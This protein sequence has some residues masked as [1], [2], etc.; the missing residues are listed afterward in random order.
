[1]R[2]KFLF[3]PDWPRIAQ[4]IVGLFFV[5]CAFNKGID[6]FF[7]QASTPLRVDLEWWISQD[8]P[9]WGYQQ[10]LVLMLPYSQIL[11]ALVIAL[12]AT[13]GLSLF[14]DINKRIGAFLLLF[15]QTNIF[16]ATALG[17]I[18]F[19][20]FIGMSIW[21][22]VYYFWQSAMTTRKRRLLTFLLIGMGMLFQ[23]QRYR[24]GDPWLSSF[25]WQESH[26]AADT[27]STS[28]ALKTL[29]LWIVER[30]IG[31]WLWASMWWITAALLLLMLTRFRLYA[32]SLWLLMLT[33]RVMIW[34][35]AVTSEGVL[36]VLT[37]FVWM[38][39]EESWQRSHPAARKK[40][41][42][43]FP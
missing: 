4:S 41:Y 35:N 1:M 13:A 17:G 27:M 10:F 7:G 36:W 11:A 25:Q 16:L 20:T 42:A 5:A 29:V 31:P 32:G 39:A 22:A 14:L 3:D 18:G 37:V 30:P 26:F 19:N 6:S 24:W 38:V 21:L 43:L 28:P 34:L 9:F 2:P 40:W 12:Q 15:V 33:L 23:Y 8:W